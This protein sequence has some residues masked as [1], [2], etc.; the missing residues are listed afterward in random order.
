MCCTKRKKRTGRWVVLCYAPALKSL[1]FPQQ[2]TV[3]QLH[4]N[5]S[6]EKH[7]YLNI[8]THT[9]KARFSVY[10]RLNDTSLD[11]GKLGDDLYHYVIWK[12]RP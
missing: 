5:I 7:V 2:D 11:L 12:S 9:V 10:L 3:F 6:L 8:A 1:S 4:R